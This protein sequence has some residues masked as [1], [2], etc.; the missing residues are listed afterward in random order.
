MLNNLSERMVNATTI[1]ERREIIWDAY[2]SGY[3]YIDEGVARIVFSHEGGVVK[4]AKSEEMV[5]FERQRV[6]APGSLK[7]GACD[8]VK[9]NRREVEAYEEITDKVGETKHIVPIT[10]YDEEYKWVIMPRVD[11]NADL[12][13]GAITE[14]KEE[15]EELGIEIRALTS[16]NVGMWGDELC[17]MDYGEGYKLRCE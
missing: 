10:E 5:E 4:I 9:Q 15:L 2:E 14:L 3:E 13:W 17:V 8:G 16:P 1:E 12:W 6:G 11:H 7:K